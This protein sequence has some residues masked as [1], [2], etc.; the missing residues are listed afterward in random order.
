MEHNTTNNA[1]KPVTHQADLAKLP[2]CLA[3]LIERAQWAVWR[4]VQQSDG[5]WQ[6]PPF[7]A[8]DLE[9]HASTK[10]PNT[11]ADYATALATVQAGQ[12]DGISYMLTD[13]DELAAADLDHCRVVA[14]G[15]IDVW[16]QHLLEQADLLG[17]YVEITPSGDGLRIWGTANGDVLHRKF[18]LDT[19]DAALELFRHTHKALTLTGLEIDRCRKL[20]CINK[21]LD[22]SALWAERHK[23]ASTAAQ[24]KDVGGF[25]G[26][27]GSAYSINAI[28]QFVRTGAPVG[29]NRSNLFHTIVGHYLGCGWSAE[30]IVAHLGQF[31]DGIGNRY[32]D[33][34]RLEQE[35]RRSITKYKTS[36]T[37]LNAGAWTG[38]SPDQPEQELEEKIDS[39]PEFDEQA[40]PH[41][42]EKEEPELEEPDLEDP[43]ELEE[44]ELAADPTLPEMYAHGDA[45]P[46]PLKD[47]LI[48][49]LIPAAGHGLLSGQWG[50][51]KT[52]MA[53][54]LAGALMTGQ[55]FLGLTVKRQCGVLFLA[56]EGADEM[57]LRIEAVVRNKCGNMQ[58]AP[59]RWYE[60]VPTLLQPGAVDKL[61][62]MAQQ[63]DD[64]LQAEFG[65]PLGL[66]LIDT[67]AASA[68][69][70]LPGAENDNAVGQAIM[71]VLK[72]VSQQ[73]SCFVLGI[74]HFGKNVETGTRGGSS[75]EASCDLVLACLGERE[76]SGRVTNTRLAIR[77]CRGG[78]QGQ[79]FP[80]TTR[81]VESPERDEDG[82][83]ITTLV[84]DW[85]TGPAATP[86]PPNDP[87]VQS[88]RTDQRNAMLRLKRVLMAVLADQGV[89]LP[90]SPDGPVLRMVDCEIVREEFYTRT[91]AK[92]S[93]EQKRK[94][95][96][97][98]FKRAI[99]SAEKQGLI[100]ICEIKDVTYLWLSQPA[101][102]AEDI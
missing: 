83:P 23:T 52:F 98:Q 97:M 2:K 49:R 62:A 36:S 48:K 82:D 92:G 43:E 57:R 64:S 67:I 56:A 101:N 85:Q 45:D 29:A 58:R 73:L 79:E 86:E 59:F 7:Q 15:S 35:I 66:I 6:K 50:A 27:T 10:D 77:K 54:D 46:R 47:W 26:G 37:P 102:T 28:E 9:R 81:V 44:D 65:L 8:R 21:L 63:A 14:T 33:E 20:G 95:R 19:G 89:D 60:T 94:F 39:A 91:I 34:G 53:L 100:G 69:Y 87:W 99:A 84:V 30:Q 78:P 93:P 12:A 68:G 76:L 96:H 13:R 1:A 88:R 41:P 74:D 25:S 38:F 32:L 3:P 90:S 40:K 80:F 11:W 16:A 22:W 5:R 18:A 42:T 55:P 72:A 75:K 4:W 24:T 31:P 61:V 51:Y 71:N 70:N 17:L